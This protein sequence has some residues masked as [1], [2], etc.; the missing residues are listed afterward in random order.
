[1]G[2]SA[3]SIE[4]IEVATGTGLEVDIY[5]RTLP[6]VIP[7]AECL[8]K[9]GDLECQC[10]QPKRKWTVDWKRKYHGVPIMWCAIGAALFV[11]GVGLGAVAVVLVVNRADGDKSMADPSSAN[12]STSVPMTISKSIPM[13][14]SNSILMTTT[15]PGQQS[16]T[17]I[18]TTESTTISATSEYEGNLPPPLPDRYSTTAPAVT[19]DSNISPTMVSATTSTT[20][21]PT[22]GLMFFRGSLGSI[23]AEQIFDSGITSWRYDVGGTVFSDFESA[24]EQSCYNQDLACINMVNG[25]NNPNRVTVDDCDA[26]QSKCIS[27]ASS[28]TATTFPS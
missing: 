20:Y 21:V 3:Y 6:E 10:A 15:G 22:A 7:K 19:T 27:A 5:D 26:Q 11:L 8:E 23:G 4:G 28:A 1:M 13:T 2:S 9:H 16:S 24:A 12:M 18:M 17:A 14:N 25:A